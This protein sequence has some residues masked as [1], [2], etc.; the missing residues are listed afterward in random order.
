MSI[1]NYVECAFV[2]GNPI[3]YGRIVGYMVTQNEDELILSS[4]RE[5]FYQHPDAPDHAVL[6]VKEAEIITRAKEGDINY[7]SIY[8][9]FMAQKNCEKICKRV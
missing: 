1:K 3:R 8:M 9:L 7:P 4:I 2:N 5:V 6:S